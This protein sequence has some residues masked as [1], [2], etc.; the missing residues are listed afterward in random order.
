MKKN[1]LILSLL[2]LSLAGCGK[3]SQPTITPSSPSVSE[4]PSISNKDTTSVAPSVSQGSGLEFEPSKTV[5][6]LFSYLDKQAREVENQNGVSYH[7]DYY[8]YELGYFANHK[9]TEKS[10]DGEAFS[11]HALFVS[12]NEKKTTSYDHKDDKDIEEDTYLSLNQREGNIYYS[13]LDYG[14]GKEKDKASKTT[15]GNSNQAT[16][17]KR[18]I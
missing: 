3:A 1:L 17:Q 14:K 16:Y 5:T 12:G 13:I 4:Q 10:E 7:R 18:R 9:V 8:F 2:S 6:S 11:N 15:V